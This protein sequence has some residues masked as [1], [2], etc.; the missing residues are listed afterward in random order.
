M[1]RSTE[2][3]EAKLAAFVDGELDA[4][5]RDDIEKHLQA[6]PQ[7]RALLD[8][9]MRGRALLRDLPSEAAPADIL[10]SIQGH[11][12]RRLLLDD[13]SDAV[14]SNRPGQL[15]GYLAIAAV[16]LLTATL[17]IVIYSVLPNSRQSTDLAATFGPAETLP[18]EALST[19]SAAAVGEGRVGGTRVAV[20]PGAGPDQ[21]RADG[22]L[23]DRA[24][25]AAVDAIRG[26]P[27][28]TASIAGRRT[29]PEVARLP[30]IGAT[31]QPPPG[32]AMADDAA[33]SPV[34]ILASDDPAATEQE[35]S[36]LLLSNRVMFE[37]V[38]PGDAETSR[39]NEGKADVASGGLAQAKESVGESI[40]IARRLTRSQYQAIDQALRSPARARKQ[41]VGQAA[42][43][44]YQSSRYKAAP[45][46]S[47]P[48]ASASGVLESDKDRLSK[49]EGSD[50]ARTG[51]GEFGKAAELDA[52]GGDAAPA[53]QPGDDADVI[54]IGD[55]LTINLPLQIQ[56]NVGGG[57]LIEVGPDGSMQ[58]PPLE[59]IAVAGL[60]VE[61]AGKKLRAALGEDATIDGAAVSIT[62]QSVARTDDT[63][64]DVV[65]VVRPTSEMTAA[66]AVTNPPTSQPSADA[67]PTAEAPAEG[68]S[69]APAGGEV[70]AAVPATQPG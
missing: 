70:P 55:Q 8:D 60:T 13:E 58:V 48:P 18:D 40:F 15:R 45:D 51:R 59:P 43:E 66:G 46:A 32:F 24:L 42:Q 47:E 29:E 64:T 26:G 37:Q 36:S 12:E 57:H 54:A 49:A 28:A 17:G 30:T 5:G 35:L 14:V 31:I 20:A 25:T 38:Q 67:A 10:E 52:M 22:V 50:V 68:P 4:A 44:Q 53:S 2:D 3:I 69:L 56:S 16:F 41:A 62:R 19:E 6:N 9:L 61:E 23:H 1:G 65:I 27:D 11:L 7:H 21:P 39:A 33:L 63:L 34:I